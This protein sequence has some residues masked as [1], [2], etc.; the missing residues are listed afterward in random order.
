MNNRQTPERSVMDEVIENLIK[1]TEFLETE[2]SKKNEALLA[3]EAQT[4]A[5]LSDF[6]KKYGDIMIQAPEP[7]LTRLESI[8]KNSLTAI[9]SNMEAW[10]KPFRKEYRISLFP[11]Q[12]KSVEY[13]SAV[14][15]RLI[16]GVAVVLFLIFS[17]MLLDKNF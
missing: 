5:L 6:E 12:T 13:V 7:D 17:Y 15:T 16:I 8:L 4:Q 3:K 10:P 11:E 9:G 2:L 1:K 14:L